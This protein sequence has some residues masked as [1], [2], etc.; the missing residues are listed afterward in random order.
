MQTNMAVT[1]VLLGQGLE[2]LSKPVVKVIRL[3]HI[4]HD[5]PGHRDHVLKAPI[6]IL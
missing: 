2:S 5:C 1:P 4:V 3:S 6:L